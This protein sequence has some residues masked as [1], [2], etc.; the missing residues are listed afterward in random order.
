MTRLA[1]LIASL[2]IFG[3]V[4]LAH[5]ANEHVRGV[6]TMISEQSVTLQVA[7]KTTKTLALSAKTTFRRAGKVAHLTDLKVGDR[8]VIDVPEATTQA[9]LIQIGVAPKA[10]AVKKAP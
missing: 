1:A 6:V 2:A 7:D 10:P 3:T 9:L 4:V 5:G 8:V